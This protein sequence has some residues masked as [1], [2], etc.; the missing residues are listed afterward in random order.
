MACV[1]RECS[2]CE[3]ADTKA[4]GGRVCPQC[5]GHLM[6]SFDEQGDHGEEEDD[7]R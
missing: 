1:M 2:D 6:V 4:H 3:Y 7:G 5:G